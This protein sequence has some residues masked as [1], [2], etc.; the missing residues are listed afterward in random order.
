MNLDGGRGLDGEPHLAGTARPDVVRLSADGRAALG[1]RDGDPVSVRGPASAITLPLA[2]TGMLDGVV[3]LPARID[4][5]GTTG[6]LGATVADRRPGGR[7]PATPARM[8]AGRKGTLMSA[9][10]AAC[11]RCWPPTGTCRW[12]RTAPSSRCWPT[13]RGGWC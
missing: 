11:G 10:F 5:I 12:A 13:T 6:R 1:V 2:V 9:S 4:G 8:R 3:W 7:Q